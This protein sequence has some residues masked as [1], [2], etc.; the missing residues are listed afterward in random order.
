MSVKNKIKKHFKKIGKKPIILHHNYGLGGI[1]SGK[2]AIIIGGGTGIGKSIAEAFISA[3]C[4]VIISSREN[5]SVEG[6]FPFVEWD[7]TEI[8]KISGTFEK[9]VAEYGQIDI[10]VNA[11]GICPPV[12][13]QRRYWDIT[14]SSFEKV[15]S[16]NLESIYFI[17]QKVCDYYVNNNIEGHILNIAST[18][19]LKGACLPYGISK[20]GVISLTKGLAK[21]MAPK[22][23]TVNGIAPGAT[24]TDMMGMSPEKDLRLD[25]IPGGRASTPQ[26]IANLAL[27]LVSDMGANMHGEIVTFDGGE[28][29][30]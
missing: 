30:R 13:F 2:R 3:N 27:F 23:I 16:V 11:Q 29:L 17:C 5:H 24:A 4:E 19:G 8:E 6:I 7:V 9:I 20:A 28:S 15:M 21:L 26:E 18:E 10:V 12:D 14:P 1:L 25:Y 22:G